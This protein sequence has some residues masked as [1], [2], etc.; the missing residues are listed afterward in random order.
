[1]AILEILMT[2]SRER[3]LHAL[4]R[5]NLPFTSAEAP[6]NYL[7]MVP[8]GEFT[9]EDLQTL[10]IQNA[11]TAACVI[12]QSTTHEDAI[13]TLLEI[14]GEDK[15]ISCWET[16][17]IPLA[18]LDVALE[19]AGVL[20]VGEDASVR[21]G[22]T[23]VDTALAATG[24]LV[25]IS[26]PGRFRA[27]SLLPPVH[28]AVVRRSQIIP[29]LEHWWAEMG[30]QNLPRMRQASNIVVVSGPSRTADIAMQLVMGMHGPGQ[31]HIILIE[32]AI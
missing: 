30:E 3:I 17:Q 32:D 15:K 1:M 7:H 20:C 18:G 9:P 21:V 10:F 8:L 12:H 5:G 4:H 28:V 27:T 23:G 13:I 24:S 22:V 14:I 31:L 2:S 25:L 6:S 16:D 26:G 11:Q 19:Q 29:D